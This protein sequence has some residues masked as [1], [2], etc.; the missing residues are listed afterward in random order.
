M[1]NS[2]A[3]M[4]FLQT[5]GSIP[6]VILVCALRSHYQERTKRPF[7]TTIA[8]SSGL[9]QR[10]IRSTVQLH[11]MPLFSLIVMEDKQMIGQQ[12]VQLSSCHCYSFSVTV[13][14]DLLRAFCHLVSGQRDLQE[15]V[16]GER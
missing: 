4:M 10:F 11:T 13:L 15:E 2:T 3:T 14:Q 5:C 6:P 9:M 16:D 8:A 7:S 12:R 1:D